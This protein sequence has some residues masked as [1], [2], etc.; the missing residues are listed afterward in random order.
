MRGV[1]IILTFVP[2]YIK[3]QTRTRIGKD[4]K[5]SSCFYPR[6]YESYRDSD[7]KTRQHYLLPLDLDDLPSWKDRYAMCHVLN[8]MVANGPSLD[9]DDT[10]VTRKAK[11]VYGQLAA[12]GLLGDVA[13]VEEKNRREL[14]SALA[15]DSL[16]N[17]RP[18]QVGAESVCLEALR[19]LKLGRFLFS[20]GWSKDKVDLALVQIAARAIYPCSEH[21]TVSC[22][23]E[24]SA[25]CE[26]FDIDPDSITKDKLYRSALDL[27]ALHDSMEDYLHGRVCNMFGLDDTVY[28]FDLTNAYMESTRCTELRRFGRSKEKRSDCPI[29]VLGAVVDKDGFLVRTKVF[30]GN[31]ADCATMQDIMALLAPPSSDGKKKIV[32]MDAGIS[33]ES[34]LEWLRQNGYDYI[35]VRRGG[36]TA[37]YKVKGERTVTVEDVRLQPIEIQFA[38]IEN[39][40]DTLLL[41]DSHAKTLKERSMHDKAAS[42]FEDGLRAIMKG[43]RSKGGTKRRDRVNER[44]GRLKE[45]CP[46]VQADYDI[47]FTYDGKDTATGMAWTRNPEKSVLRS[48]SEGKYLVQTSLKGCDEKQIWEYYNVIRRVEAVFETLKTDLDV[49]PVYHQNDVAV[50][51]HFNLAILAYWIVSTTQYQLRQKGSRVSWREVRRIASTQHVVST[52]AKRMDG[53]LVEVRQCTEP[54]ATLLELYKKLDMASPPLKRKR[55]IC[56]VHFTKFKKNDT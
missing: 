32:V 48:G 44:L 17:V 47:S 37:P 11:S 40:D 29:V 55:K 39:V 56:V 3:V 50:K 21:K 23:R 8:D 45:R 15:E 1:A 19:R 28:L 9:L 25:L 30:S 34:N 54:E 24:N 4:G 41:V 13:K 33:I 52:V 38:E 22:L 7:G 12:K 20:K 46:S 14:S 18:R 16:K 51:A 6:L 27:Y 36:S 35:T 26:F 42:R 10:P 5:K 49:R 2:M 43:I 53:Q 31:T